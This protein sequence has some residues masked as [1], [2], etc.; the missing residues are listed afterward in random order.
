MHSLEPHF[1]FEFGVVL[2]RGG[3][4]RP[5]EEAVKRWADYCP[6][7]YEELG[8]RF[9]IL[10]ALRDDRYVL[11]T[12]SCCTRREFLLGKERRTLWHA[13]R[14]PT[15]EVITGEH[16]VRF[17][18]AGQQPI[19]PN[20]EEALQQV[21][22]RHTPIVRPAAHW[23]G[24]RFL[25]RDSPKLA[26]E[27]DVLAEAELIVE[28]CIRLVHG[29]Q[30]G[31]PEP[32]IGLDMALAI[33]LYRRYRVDLRHWWGG[34]TEFPPADVTISGLRWPSDSLRA[35]ELLSALR[36][37]LE[38]PLCVLT[39]PFPPEH[40]AWATREERWACAAHVV[41]ILPELQRKTL[42]LQVELAI[43]RTKGAKPTDYEATRSAPPNRPSDEAIRLYMQSVS[44]GATQQH[45]ADEYQ[46]ATGLPM[47][48]GQ[49]SRAIS[50]VK[51]WLDAGNTLPVISSPAARPPK[52]MNP[53]TLDM[54]ATTDRRT[55]SQRADR[56]DE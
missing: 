43:L 45:I 2:I 23:Q 31:L 36:E 32:P 48:Q 49:V 34:T 33:L 40:P 44:T 3:V 5:L 1:A 29:V 15:G 13:D 10:Y 21:V 24:K 16:A 19:P 54:G 27:I 52:S 8:M 12:Y 38:W 46:I 18:L 22:N 20:L 55:P 50:R 6:E 28:E 53:N 51:S 42:E 30:N 39:L 37:D 47:T 11:L 7:V 14:P 9:R 56:A 17:L 26:H 4:F 35:R 41:E 25:D